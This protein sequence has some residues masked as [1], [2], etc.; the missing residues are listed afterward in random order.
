MQAAFAVIVTVCSATIALADD[1]KTID[2]KEY[3]TQR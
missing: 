2:G 3:K 1:F